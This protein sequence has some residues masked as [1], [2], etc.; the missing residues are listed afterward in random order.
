MSEVI[1]VDDESLDSTFRLTVPQQGS[2]LY[3]SKNTTD[4]STPH[5]TPSAKLLDLHQ[6]ACGVGGGDRR[7]IWF[8]VM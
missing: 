5:L 4:D 6:Q 7:G 3:L 1:I 2:L 8:N